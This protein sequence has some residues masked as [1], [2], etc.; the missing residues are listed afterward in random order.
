MSSFNAKKSRKVRSVRS[1]R[2][3]LTE[4][5]R[6]QNAIEN[7]E[8]NLVHNENIEIKNYGAIITNDNGNSFELTNNKDNSQGNKVVELHFQKTLFEKG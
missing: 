7:S 4:F 3:Y 2:T 6:V 5:S 8:K 1:Q